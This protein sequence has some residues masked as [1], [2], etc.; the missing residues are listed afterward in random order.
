[1]KKKEKKNRGLRPFYNSC[2][3]L[4]SVVRSKGVEYDSSRYILRV[5]G[6]RLFISVYFITLQK[7]IRKSNLETDQ[8]ILEPLVKIK[9]RL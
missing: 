4:A 9:H 7:V 3:H 5:W 8:E 6:K 2:I 1:M